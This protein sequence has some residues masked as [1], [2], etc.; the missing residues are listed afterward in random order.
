M[1]YYLLLLLGSTWT[2]PS[3]QKINTS[4]KSSHGYEFHGPANRVIFLLHEIRVQLGYHK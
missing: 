4:T 2:D 3:P 1:G